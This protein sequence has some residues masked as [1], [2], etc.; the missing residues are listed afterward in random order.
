MRP[1]LGAAESD[2]HHSEQLPPVDLPADGDPGEPARVPA[3][4]ALERDP[5]AL[6]LL[7]RRRDPG[8]DPAALLRPGLLLRPGRLP[9]LQPPQ[10]G[11]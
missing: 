6:G 8:S 1:S 4:A 7:P 11:H 10:H 9:R 3:A 5:A 2:D